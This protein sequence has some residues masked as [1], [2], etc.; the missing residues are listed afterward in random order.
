MNVKEKFIN[1][2]SLT[3][4][5]YNEDGKLEEVSKNLEVKDGFVELGLEHCSEYVLVETSNNAQTG[6]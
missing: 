5:Y 1:G 2:T 4:Y 6:T 3:L